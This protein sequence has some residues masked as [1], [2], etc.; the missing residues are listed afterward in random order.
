MI[1]VQL[2][3]QDQIDAICALDE[4]AR[5]NN[6]RRQFIRR[7]VAEKSCYV[8][9]GPQIIGYAVL[10]YSFFAQGFIA[11]LYVQQ[12]WRQQGVGKILLE[13]LEKVCQTH[14]LFTSTNLSNLPMQRLLA[15]LN[16]RLSGVIHDLDEGDPEL[17]Y[18]KYLR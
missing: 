17:V 5:Y 1:T 9:A 14:K 11:M 8:A 10:D 3:A 4:I 12:E 7:A 16:Y 18:V 15:K 6:E 2:A 13:Y